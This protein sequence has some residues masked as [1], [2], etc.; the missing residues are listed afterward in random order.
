MTQFDHTCLALFLLS[1]TWHLLLKKH[2]I[3]EKKVQE[4]KQRILD[5]F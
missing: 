4:W 2:F 3:D 5:K 1:I